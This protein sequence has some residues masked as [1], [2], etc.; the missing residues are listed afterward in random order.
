MVGGGF[1]LKYKIIV[2]FSPAAFLRPAT[3]AKVAC[4]L[5]LS[6]VAGACQCVLGQGGI[7]TTIAGGGANATAALEADIGQPEGVTVDPFGN[8]IVAASAMNQVFKIDPQGTFSVLAGTGIAGF[9]GDNG[10]AR[11][12]TLYRP[13]A[14]A[15]DRFGNI[16]IVD[17]NNQRIRRVDALSGIITTVAGN[18]IYAY[19]G[20]GGP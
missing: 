18:G 20:D 17:T 4:A 10:P 8:I 7:I 1:S 3:L 2:V 14:V 16:F 15:S 11:T 19:S 12:A 5:V 6:L 13:W 9:S